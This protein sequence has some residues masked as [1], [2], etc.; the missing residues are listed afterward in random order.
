M[1]RNWDVIMVGARVAGAATAMLLARAGLD[2][3]CLDRGRYGSDTISTHALMRGGVMLLQDW[4]LLPELVAAGTPPVRRTVFH[5]GDESV[6][7]SIKPSAGVDALYAPRRTVLD[8]VLVDAAERA[9]ASVRFGTEVTGLRRDDT[10]RV[11]GVLLAGRHGSKAVVEADLV[12]GADGRNSIVASSVGAGQANGTNASSL[13]YGYWAQLP[14]DGYE[15]S[16]RAGLAAGAIPT[17]AGLTCVFVGARPTR[18]DPAVRA[19]NASTI[20]GRLSTRMG[21][22][23]RIAAADQVGPV[24]HIRRLPPG[25]LRRAFGPGWALV[26]D[27]GLWMDPMSTHGMT[28][29]L[30]DATLLSRAVAASH[31][32][33]DRSVALSRYEA[34]RDQLSRPMMAATEDIASYTWDLTRIRALLRSLSSAMTDEVELLS[35]IQPPAESLPTKPHV[36]GL[37]Y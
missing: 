7:V 8:R 30:R 35:A 26:G 34:D 21:L 20:F 10:G 6:A 32:D 5:Y 19:Q 15:W 37:R 14:T 4:G 22:R 11:T 12:V 36:I 31:S 16:Y 9:G 23:D 24:R 17:N 33:Q 18:L 27:A 13:L 1:K 3:L 28:S 25:Y 29:A 2:V